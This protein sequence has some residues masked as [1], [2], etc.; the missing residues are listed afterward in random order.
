[1]NRKQKLIESL[2]LVIGALKNGTIHYDWKEQHSCNAGVVAQAVLE[3]TRDG[4]NE[5]R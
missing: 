4:I 2:R 1:M 5:R 3:E